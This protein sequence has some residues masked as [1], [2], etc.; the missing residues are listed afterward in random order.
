MHL[1]SSGR[2]E[3]VNFA[4]TRADVV[5]SGVSRP[6]FGVEAAEAAFK[7]RPVVARRGGAAD[8]VAAC[9]TDGIED[10]AE[11][12]LDQ[13]ADP[14]RAAALVRE[15]RARAPLLPRLVRDWR[16]LL[17]ALASTPRGRGGAAE[18]RGPALIA[19]SPE[20]GGQS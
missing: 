10:T 7:G 13:L 9:L 12:V 11:R 15:G 6:A 16:R 20:A 8:A 2:R 19:R 1:F 18:V 14:R 5:L 4:R 17:D 3:H